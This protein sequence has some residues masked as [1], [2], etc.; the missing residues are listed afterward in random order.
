MK[1]T[2][3]LSL[4]LKRRVDD[5]ADLLHD[6]FVFIHSSGR[7]DSRADYLNLPSSGALTYETMESSDLAVKSAGDSLGHRRSSAQMSRPTPSAG[8]R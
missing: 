1:A 6:D 5:L 3:S 8:R 4:S 2:T 7:V